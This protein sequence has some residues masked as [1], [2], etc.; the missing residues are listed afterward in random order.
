MCNVNTVQCRPLKQKKENKA[1]HP[2]APLHSGNTLPEQ[3]EICLNELFLLYK[4]KVLYLSHIQRTV[5]LDLCSLRSSGHSAATAQR[6]GTN[7]RSEPA[8]TQRVPTGDR[9][10]T[11]VFNGGETHKNM[12]RTR[13]LNTDR[14]IEPRTILL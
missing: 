10:D 7:S 13:K 4:V 5:K 1:V 9:L 3:T 2:N 14:G 8:R 11:H 6:P 12:R